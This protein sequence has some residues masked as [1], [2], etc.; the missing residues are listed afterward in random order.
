MMAS[1][2]SWRW[3]IGMACAYSAATPLGYAQSAADFPSKPI[4]FISPAV[5][6]AGSDTTARAIAHKLTQAWGQQVIVDNRAGASGLI[7]LDVLSKAI[8]DG[9]T[10]VLI[11]ANVP[12]NT[13]INPAWPYDVGKDMKPLSQVTSLF[14]IAYHHPAAP[15]ATFK[16]LLSYGRTHPGKLYYSSPGTG[17][18][19]HLGWE[20]I[21]Q[22]SGAKFTHVPYKSGT[23][24]ITATIAGETQFGFGTLISLR[25]HMVSGRIRTIAVTSRQRA[26]TLP[27]VPTVA[28][29]GLP[30]YEIDQWYGAVTHAKVPAA[31]VSKL[32]AGIVAAVKSPDVAQ[33]LAADG[34]TAVGSTAEQFSA[35]INAETGKW[36]KVAKESGVVLNGVFIER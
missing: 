36:R 32:T 16:E 26:P 24:A 5:P 13:A 35:T 6:G 27:D 33:R 3:A 22:M 10:L 28:E 34:S 8:P 25:P 20:I 18:L 14:Y 17:S 1:T 29:S 31:V 2:T 4:R 30:G 11:S 15:V 21:I 12:V 7:A 23:P 19:Q 9:H